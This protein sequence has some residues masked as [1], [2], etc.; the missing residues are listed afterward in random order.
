MIAAHPEAARAKLEAS[1]RDLLLRAAN[2]AN[3]LHDGS[4]GRGRATWVTAGLRAARAAVGLWSAV[5][6]APGPWPRCAL[7]DARVERASITQDVARC[8]TIVA[9]R[10]HG[11]AETMTFRDELLEDLHGRDLVAFRGAAR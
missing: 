11:E 4:Y 8:S 1:R 10:C 6:L 3:A 5:E 7:C 9:V 2:L